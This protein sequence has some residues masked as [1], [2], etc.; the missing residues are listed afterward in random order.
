ME[1]FICKTYPGSKVTDLKC[2]VRNIDRYHLKAYVS[3]NLSEP[4]HNIY[5][6]LEP[7]F[8]FSRYT[9]IAGHIWE[10]VCAWFAGTRAS[11]LFNYYVPLIQKYSNLNHSCPYSGHL[12]VKMDNISME[13]FA[14]PQILPA[15]RYYLD[16]Y[17][18][19]SDRSKSKLL[20]NIKLYASVSDHRIEIV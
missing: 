2:N 6:H 9:R 15:G 10:D 19:E 20:F 12:V 14:F 11:F 18:T 13:R 3:L 17:F 1:R 8:K 16:S 5:Y 4:I 7:Y